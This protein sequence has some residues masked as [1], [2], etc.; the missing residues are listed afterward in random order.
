M[1]CN[2][3]TALYINFGTGNSKDMDLSFLTGYHLDG[4]YCPNDGYYS[5]VPSTS[6]CF[7]GNWVTVPQ[8]HTPGDVNGKMMLVNSSEEPGEFF[9]TKISGL[10]GSTIYEVSAWIM[11]VCRRTEGCQTLYPDIGFTISNTTGTRYAGFYTGQIPTEQAPIWRRYSFTFTTPPIL[12]AVYLVL[13]NKSPGGCG[14]DFA[15]DDILVTRCEIIPPET[16]KEEHKQP[17]KPIIKPRQNI[18][19]PVKK[20]IPA[21]NRPAPSEIVPVIKPTIK[22]PVKIMRPEPRILQSRSNPVVKEIYIDSAELKIEIYDN[23]VIDG[24]TVS[25]YHNNELVIA[26]AALLATPIKLTIKVDTQHPHHELVMVA[27]NLGSIPPNTSLMIIT[28]KDKRYEVFISSDDKKNAKIII[29]LK[30]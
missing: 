15:L 8:D 1:V 11:N 24:D 17:A 23:G 4:S 18:P 28:A 13:N 29:N 26:H 2:K 19:T 25:V 14:N 20:D 3:D 16:K 9:V 10:R 12:R 27:D 30:E 22:E 21:T 6:D 5:F 7:G